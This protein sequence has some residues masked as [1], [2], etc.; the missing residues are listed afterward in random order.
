VDCFLLQRH[1][2]RIVPVTE[3][4]YT[5]SNDSYTFWVYGDEN[6]V[7]E[8]DYPLKRCGICNIL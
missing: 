1:F 7:Y 6:E 5:Y 8:E 2:V 3:V 4:T